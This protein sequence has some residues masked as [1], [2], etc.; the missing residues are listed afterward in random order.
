MQMLDDAALRRLLGRAPAHPR[1]LVSGSGNVPFELLSVVDE[2]FDEYVLHGVNLPRGIPV[3]EGITHETAFLGAGMRGVKQLRYLPS[4]LSMVPQ[5]VRDHC[6]PDVV[7]VQVS[8]V[9]D[10]RV[11]LGIDCTILPTAIETVK[12]RGGILVGQVN[13]CVPYT[14]GDTEVPV[15]LFDGLWS[16]DREV[17]VDLPPAV[18]GPAADA[19][20]RIGELCAARVSDG[21]TL[22]L[23]IG[24]V[25]DAT[26]PV[27]ATRRGLKVWTELISDGL[28]HL[29]RAGAL[30]RDSVVT[31]SIV[32]G[33]RELYDHID[34]NE[35]LRMR[36]CEVTNS[37]VNIAAQHK[38]T[39]INTAL[40]VD[41]LGQANA[42]RIGRRIF[43]GFGGQTDFIVGAMHAPGGQALMALRSWHAKAD[44]STIVGVLHEPT[45]S[46][47]HTAIVTENGVAELFGRSEQEQALGMIENAA[48]PR[49]RELLY[50]EATELGLV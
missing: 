40:Q 31:S 34:R 35:R 29:H 39:S 20:L 16:H 15:D 50:L 10:G 49:V 36:R 43:S 17:A 24:E 18:P 46:F 5:L 11:S 13:T 45:T 23:G 47:Q 7:V 3:R 4:R 25:P 19:A 38:M 8:R 21:S 44:T 12:A 37:T 30:D 48:H 27:L 9:V 2:C 14:F 32:I 6:P 22:Q 33:S 41:L 1:V 42:S 26:L 28:L